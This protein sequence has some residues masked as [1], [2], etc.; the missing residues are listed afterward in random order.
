M[1]WHTSRSCTRFPKCFN[2]NIKDVFKDDLDNVKK[3]LNYS[4]SKSKTTCPLMS[5][6]QSFSQSIRT[7]TFNVSFGLRKMQR[8]NRL[9]DIA[10]SRLMENII[11]SEFEKITKQGTRMTPEHSQADL[12]KIETEIRASARRYLPKQQE[13]I[14]Y[15]MTAKHLEHRTLG[16]TLTV[17][18]YIYIP[19]ADHTGSR[20]V[21]CRDSVSTS[22]FSNQWLWCQPSFLSPRELL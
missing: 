15:P 5:K 6:L 21:E 17:L 19:L 1:A 20:E 11:H 13:W 10:D 8:S 14:E 3:F 4:V 2:E 12:R 16:R 7:K 22:N 9:H 18:K